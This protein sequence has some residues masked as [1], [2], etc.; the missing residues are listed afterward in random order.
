[1]SVGK[2]DIVAVAQHVAAQVH[3]TVLAVVD[4][5]AVNGEGGELAAQASR[6]YGFNASHSAIVFECH[7]HEAAC[8]IAQE[9]VAQLHQLGGS[10]DLRGGLHVQ[11]LGWDVVGD[12]V[13]LGESDR[14][15]EPLF[16]FHS[17]GVLLCGVTG[18]LNGVLCLTRV[19]EHKQQ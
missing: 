15:L 6:R 12:D 9:G 17:A 8:G 19:S 13:Y 11:F 14:G 16:G 7:T 5:H 4:G 18:M 2:G 3:L 10:N 1:M